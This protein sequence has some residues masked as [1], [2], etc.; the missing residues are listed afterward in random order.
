[1][2][3][4]VAIGFVFSEHVSAFVKLVDADILGVSFSRLLVQFNIKK[5]LT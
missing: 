5:K 1:M 3:N 4:N 2:A